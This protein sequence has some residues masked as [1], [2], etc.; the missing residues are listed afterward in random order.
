MAFSLC[1]KSSS[2]AEAAKVLLAA[3]FAGVDISFKR[4]SKS[5]DINLRGDGFE[6]KG[7]STQLAV[8]GMPVNRGL[9][10]CDAR[11]PHLAKAGAGDWY[12][13][14]PTVDQWIVFSETT[15]EVAAKKMISALDG[16]GGASGFQVEVGRFGWRVSA[17]AP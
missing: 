12:A 4:D 17:G 6:Q 10:A 14:N 13:A 16:E 2:D 8:H 15:L 7:N 9:D 3:K 5:T 11:A 1:G